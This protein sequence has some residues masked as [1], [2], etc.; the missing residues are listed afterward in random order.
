M[1]EWRVGLFGVEIIEGFLDKQSDE[2]QLEDQILAP[3]THTHTHTVFAWVK[4]GLCHSDKI[5][6]VIKHDCSTLIIR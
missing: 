4:S 6:N 1:C 2:W 3:C 5:L